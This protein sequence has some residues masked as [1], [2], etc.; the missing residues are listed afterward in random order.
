MSIGSLSN[1]ASSYLESLVGNVLSN[2]FTTGKTGSSN[3]SSASRTPDTNQLSPFAELLSTLQQLQQSNPTQ[4]QQVTQQIAT[5]LTTAANTA[6]SNGNPT[7][8]A[9]LTQLATDFTNAS[10][11]GQLPNI[12]DL[13]AA[14]QTGHHGHHGHHC[15][16]GSGSTDSAGASSGSST[17]GSSSTDLLS[18]LI[19]SY[20]ST[21]AGVN[22]T[23]D[24]MAIIANT[25]ASAGIEL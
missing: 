17:S 13:A 4:Y 14:Q 8:A 18:Q 2:R 9:T 10:Q 1:L 22:Q 20:Q 11:N 16:G 21:A 19:A 12:Q 15:H 6:T 3:A 7:A 24:P 5:N 25:L 23:T